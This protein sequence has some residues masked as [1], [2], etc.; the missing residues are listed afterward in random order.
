MCVEWFSLILLQ[1]DSFS[2][3]D[4][5]YPGADSATFSFITL[6]AVAEALGKVKHQLL[7]ETNKHIFLVIF[8][9]VSLLLLSSFVVI[10]GV[11]NIRFFTF[12]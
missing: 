7:K 3:F 4:G 5:Q 12:C 6:F 10:R 11:Q 8:H 1:Y 9:G 2:M